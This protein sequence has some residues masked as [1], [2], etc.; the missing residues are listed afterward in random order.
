M[1]LVVPLPEAE[2]AGDLGQQDEPVLAFRDLRRGAQTLL[3]SGRVLEV[4][5]AAQSK[6][7]RVRHQVSLL[8]WHREALA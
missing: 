2:R 3:G 4:P 1:A 7:C 8:A 5:Q 6:G